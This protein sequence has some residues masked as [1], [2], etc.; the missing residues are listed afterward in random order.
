[1]Q[2]MRRQMQQARRQIEEQKNKFDREIA[3]LQE[4]GLVLD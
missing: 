2:Q 4:V 3:V 1:M